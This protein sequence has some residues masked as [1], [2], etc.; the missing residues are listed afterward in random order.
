ME[1]DILPELRIVL[2]LWCGSGNGAPFPAIDQKAD[3]LDVM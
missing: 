2:T 3:A 1:G